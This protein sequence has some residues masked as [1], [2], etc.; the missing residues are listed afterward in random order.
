MTD[1]RLS[2]TLTVSPQ[3]HLKCVTSKPCLDIFL[4]LIS[5]CVRDVSILV[6]QTAAAAAFQS[7]LAIIFCPQLKPPTAIHRR[8]AQ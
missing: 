4:S 7:R 3:K 6:R 5:E 1:Y 2:L 8:K